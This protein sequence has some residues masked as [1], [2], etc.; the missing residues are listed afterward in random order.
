M[1]PCQARQC[2]VCSP[3]VQSK[4]HG[5]C[6]SIYHYLSLGLVVQGTFKQLPGV[7]QEKKWTQM[8]GTPCSGVTSCSS[9]IGYGICLIHTATQTLS[10]CLSLA[11]K[12]AFRNWV[13]LWECWPFLS[14]LLHAGLPTS[15]IISPRYLFFWW[16]S[17]AFQFSSQDIENF[18]I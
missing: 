6:C 12:G 1:W 3:S 2:E 18:A 10:L 14:C 9:A 7:I 4:L 13:K 15:V 5:F 8:E 11:L 16:V 17:Q